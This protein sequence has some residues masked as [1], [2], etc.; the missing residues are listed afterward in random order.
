MATT[1]KREHEK[2]REHEKDAHRHTTDDGRR[3]EACLNVIGVDNDGL[4]KEIIVMGRRRG[5]RRELNRVT[6]VARVQV[7]WCF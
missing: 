5:R 7:D 4:V 3:V 1:A 6:K 2:E